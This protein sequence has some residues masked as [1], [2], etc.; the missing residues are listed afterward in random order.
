MNEKELLLDE[1]LKKDESDS[2]IEFKADLEPC[3]VGEYISALSNS[4]CLKHTDFGYLV[5]GIEDKTKKIVGTKFN[6]KTA[7][8]KSENN[9][10]SLELH[11]NRYISPKINYEFYE[12]E[13]DNKKVVILEIAS[14]DGEPTFYKGKG[15]CR[16]N[17]SK[18]SLGN[19]P[20]K[21]IKKIY[22]SNTDWSYELA[23]KNNKKYSFDDLDEDAV[24]KACKIIITNNPHLEKFK[25]S[26][27]TLLTKAKIL[28]EDGEVV[29]ATMLLLGKSEFFSDFGEIKI[30]FIGWKVGIGELGGAET[31]KIPFLL[32]VERV[33]LKIRTD[34]IKT[35][36]DGS[37]FPDHDV[38]DKY[39]KEACL[40]AIN[41]C[42][43]HN[44]YFESKIIAIHQYQDEKMERI[45]VKVDFIDFESNGNF[46]DGKPQDYFDGKKTPKRYRNKFLAEAMKTLRMGVDVSG[47]G[48]NF[49]YQKQL[50]KY[51]PAPDFISHCDD[52]YNE[53]F[54]IRIYGKVI[55]QKFSEILINHPDFNIL[56]IVLLDKIQKG[57]GEE[58]DIN[59][60]NKLK[61]EK[62]IEGRRPQYILS[63]KVAELLGKEAEYTKKKG[64]SD[65]KISNFIIE[66]LE[67]FSNGQTRKQINEYVWDYLSEILSKEQKIRKIN[68]I[69]YKLQKKSVIKNFG[70]DKVPLWKLLK[71]K[72]N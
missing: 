37:L 56:K 1:L 3:L 22:N 18:T 8:V 27:K 14:A 54:K 28:N 12:L 55:D 53:T 52:F 60:A 64:F 45:D 67:N 2:Y 66:H 57:F 34:I 31:F 26:P 51:F 62:L 38:I 25:N 16:I 58:V 68:Y 24:D 50:D 59:D 10:E 44:D 17:E 30:K 29:N 72:I 70:T 4:A 21:L 46:Y 42:I 41:N 19:L 7:K 33:Y 15:Y 35:F 5:L 23:E 47:R 9:K 49:I 39:D 13:I 61:E 48:I 36:P 40:E 63:S 65:D 6:I 71:N 43:A 20:Q 32:E 69:L 11:L